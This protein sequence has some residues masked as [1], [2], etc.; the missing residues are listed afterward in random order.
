LELLS[1]NPELR[2]AFASQETLDQV[3]EFTYHID[4]L[5]QSILHYEAEN[6]ELKEDAARAEMAAMYEE[7]LYPSQHPVSGARRSTRNIADD[8]EA[9]E[10]NAVLMNETQAEQLSPAMAKR[11]QYLN[12]TARSDT[13]QV[14]G[15]TSQPLLEVWDLQNK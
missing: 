2:L 6:A 3:S 15:R 14:D 12:A 5:E 1:S 13:H 4:Q 7:V 9:D 10:S 8:F 11:A